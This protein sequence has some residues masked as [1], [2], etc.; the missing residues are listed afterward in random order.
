MTRSLG[1]KLRFASAPLDGALGSLLETGDL[2]VA[3]IARIAE[4][5]GRR[6]NPIY[7]VHKW[8]ARRFSCSFRAILVA[9]RLSPDADFWEA[10]Y[11]GVDYCG[12][13]VLDPFVGGGTS[14][15][16][17]SL[18]GANTLGVDIDPVACAITRFELDAGQT[19]DL[20]AEMRRLDETVGEQL[21]RY[22]RTTGR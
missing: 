10:Y 9:A 21:S 2:P 11:S 20:S 1:R 6:P 22:Y 15:V 4:R 12:R 13:T 3:G 5:E 14:V 18:L 16:E 7:Q 8:F 19:P 17:A